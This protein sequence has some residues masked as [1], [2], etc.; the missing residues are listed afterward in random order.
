ME[1]LSHSEL[2][3]L[4]SNPDNAWNIGSFGAIGEF[5]H[6]PHEHSVVR[7]ETDWFEIHTNRGG[8]RIASV[9]DLQPFAWDRLS[10]DGESWGYSVALC[11][12]IPEDASDQSIRHLGQDKHAIREGEDAAELFDLGVGVGVVRMAIRTQDQELISDLVAHEGQR[13]IDA[14]QL[15]KQIYDAQPHRIAFS[16]AGRI[17]VYQPIPAPDG[18]SPDGPHTHLLMNLVPKQ[19]P[20]P[21]TTPIPDGMQSVLN[22]TP[23]SPWRTNRGERHTFDPVQDAALQPY[24]ERF[25]LAEDREVEEKLRDQ[26]S[27][28][29]EP[30]RNL[31]PKT[32]RGRAK[33]RIVLRRMAVDGNSRVKAWRETFDKARATDY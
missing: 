19:Q 4:A 32:R 28:G 29:Q 5:L 12:P 3:E 9:D 14:P 10:G 25:G 17:E 31:W 2:V 22:F 18:E 27:K 20:H 13:L 1:T 24:L 21:A 15:G 8:M 23:K 7:H 30:D 26:I 16:P 6:D 33:A 11:C